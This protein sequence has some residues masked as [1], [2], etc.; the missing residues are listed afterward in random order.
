MTIL[1]LNVEPNRAFLLLRRLHDAELLLVV[2][3]D[4]VK[5]SR[6]PLHVPRRHDDAG[7]QRR[8]RLED[9]NEVQ[10]KLLLVELRLNK[11]SINATH[12]LVGGLKLD[13]VVGLVGGGH[14]VICLLGGKLQAAIDGEL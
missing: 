1:V 13:L 4:V 2:G 11:V 8:H 7:I 5:E 3:D 9:V 6:Q 12:R 14:R 10:D